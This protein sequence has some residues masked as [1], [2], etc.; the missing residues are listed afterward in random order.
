MEYGSLLSPRPPKLVAAKCYLYLPPENGRIRLCPLFASVR[1]VLDD[2]MQTEIGRAW[3]HRLV[4]YE[5]EVLHELDFL[6]T[7]EYQSMYG[8]RGYQQFDVVQLVVHD[9]G[10]RFDYLVVT[11]RFE[12]IIPSPFLPTGLTSVDTVKEVTQFILSASTRWHQYKNYHDWFRYFME[13][14]LVLSN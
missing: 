2:E 5:D 4:V 7:D 3:G 12:K 10:D 1:V 14:R 6:L 13:N 9:D 11:R 8:S